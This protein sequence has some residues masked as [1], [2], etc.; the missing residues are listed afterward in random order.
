MPTPS[1]NGSKHWFNGLPVD[2][3]QQPDK[4]TGSTKY[5]FNGLPL[6]FLA[7][8]GSGPGPTAVGR[9]FVIIIQ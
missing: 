5:W 2:A 6:D 1:V 8:Y 3:V 9:M 7:S 4:N